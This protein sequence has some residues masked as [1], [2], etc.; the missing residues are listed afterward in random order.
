MLLVFTDATDIAVAEAGRIGR[1]IPVGYYFGAVIAVQSVPGSKPDK[2]LTVLEDGFYGAVR[3]SL[4]IRNM[5]KCQ[6]GRLGGEGDCANKRRHT[7]DEIIFH[8]R[9]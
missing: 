2:S 6:F 9:Q 3:Q 7:T 5:R 1:V 8:D 4:I